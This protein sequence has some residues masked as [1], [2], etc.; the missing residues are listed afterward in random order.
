MNLLRNSMMLLREVVSKPLGVMETVQ[1][2]RWVWHSSLGRGSEMRK[3]RFGEQGASGH[4][5]NL[6]YVAE[7][8]I[9]RLEASSTWIM[10]GL[11]EG[12]GHIVL[13][14]GAGE[15]QNVIGKVSIEVRFGLQGR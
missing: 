5:W 12:P 6:G 8:R 4:G 15:P 14:E 13:S 9:M 1:N 11:T 3:H 2:G 10:K 7:I